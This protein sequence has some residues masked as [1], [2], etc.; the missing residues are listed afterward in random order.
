MAQHDHG[1]FALLG[2]MQMNSVRFDGAMGNAGR[3][4]R[5]PS[6]ILSA[7]FAARETTIARQRAHP[8]RVAAGVRFFGCSARYDLSPVFGCSFDVT[9]FFLVVFFSGAAGGASTRS[10]SDRRPPSN[11]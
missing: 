7:D 3:G 11:R 5:R 6:P 4:H 1:P 10:I 8:V 9:G 2:D